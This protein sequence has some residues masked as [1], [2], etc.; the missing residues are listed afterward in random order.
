MLLWTIVAP[1][2]WHTISINIMGHFPLAQGKRFIISFIDV[3]SRYVV[4]DAAAYHT[5]P[6]VDIG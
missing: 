4:L 3:F 6:M 1:Q 2:L 5:A